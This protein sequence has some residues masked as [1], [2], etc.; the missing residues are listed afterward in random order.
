MKNCTGTMISNGRS[1][2]IENRPGPEIP[3]F[4]FINSDRMLSKTWLDG[5]TEIIENGP[6]PEIPSFF[7]INSDRV[8]SKAKIERSEK[9]N[10]DGCRFF[11]FQ[12]FLVEF[13]I[14][15]VAGGLH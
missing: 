6:G 5:R 9:I 11:N 12:L 10:Q 2:I 13:G 8:F 14:D 15:I 4:F 7:F 3:S 1:E